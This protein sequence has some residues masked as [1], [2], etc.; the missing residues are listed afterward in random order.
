MY[1]KEILDIC[2]KSGVAPLFVGETGVGKS[3]AVETWVKAKNAELEAEGKKPF[4]YRQLCLGQMSP[5]D[6]QGVGF[7][8]DSSI[9]KGQQFTRFAPCKAFE[10]DQPICLF[11]DEVNRAHPGVVQALFELI[12]SKT[13]TSSGYS[14]PEGSFIVLA[15][16]PQSG[17]G[18]YNLSSVLDTAFM[19]RVALIPVD[20]DYNSFKEFI[21]GKYGEDTSRRLDLMGMLFEKVS[22]CIES[23]IQATASDGSV[24]GYSISPSNRK[25]DMAFGVLTKF[26]EDFANINR[27]PKVR[28]VALKRVLTGL[29]GE[30]RAQIL[31]STASL[32]YVSIQEFIGE[33]LPTRFKFWNN[34]LN[35]GLTG[36]INQI[37]AFLNSAVVYVKNRKDDWLTQPKA[38]DNLKEQ[39][40]FLWL[41]TMVDGL[42]DAKYVNY[43]QDTLIAEGLYMLSNDIERVRKL[44]VKAKTD[45]GSLTQAE[46]I[47]FDKYENLFKAIRSVYYLSSEKINKLNKLKEKKAIEKGADKFMEGLT[48]EEKAILSEDL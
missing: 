18:D 31:M 1:V 30:T 46:R 13:I 3:M 15:G 20:S 17:E 12:L 40:I 42:N 39:N 14:L 29:I 6:V 37:F 38:E 36:K 9:M 11:L 47:E 24:G 44:M 16:N 35:G 48:D 41:F 45:E 26:G 23:N 2:L 33:D 10:A 4:V 43:V 21:G 22:F 28:A 34:M 19:G 32:E 27:I 5:G 25:L 8:E 7:L